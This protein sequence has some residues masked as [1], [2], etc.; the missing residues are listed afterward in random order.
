MDRNL[1]DRYKNIPNLIESSVNMEKSNSKIIIH[2]GDFILKSNKRELQITGEI[3][4][5]W[6]PNKGTEFTGL[7]KN[8]NEDLFQ[9]FDARENLKLIINDLEMGEVFITK[10][11]SDIKGT[12]SSQAVTGDKSISV[13]KLNFSIPNLREFYGNS[14]KKISDDKIYFTRGRIELEA[15][16][17]I[18]RIDKVDN[19]KEL[20]SD[21]DENGGYI[22]LYGGEIVSKN[23]SISYLDAEKIIYQL[24]TFL[25]FINGRRTSALMING[26]Y[27]NETKWCDYTSYFVDTF[28]SSVTT[29]PTL[30][31][32][33]T[34]DSLWKNYNEIWK[35]ENHRDFLATAIHWYVEANNNS[36]FAEGSII[37]A[38]TAL[39]LIYNWWIIENKKL[40]QGKDSE[41]LSASNKIRLLISHLDILSDVP[42][43]FENLQK[44]VDNDKQ[45]NDAPEAIVQ[46]RNAV[47]HSQQEKR[48]K[49]ISI[50]LL[51]KYE[52]LQLS[53]W[54]I[55]LSILKILNFNGNYYN[56]TSSELSRSKSEELVPWMKT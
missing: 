28:K 35:D 31:S 56:R 10:I 39:E 13:E 55:E 20:K 12:F 17:Y 19:F 3:Y 2:K 46:I 47:V 48:K 4:F 34:F 30:N 6:I 27:E 22:I 36:G 50:H 21:L 8:S 33:N 40:I 24:N 49:L 38:Q 15:N 11:G 44:F 25:T 42:M 14:I 52:A 41:S 9:F 26:I 5:R 7:T 23:G 54:Y 37:M 45:I 53:L 16:E 51:A 18:I 43:G 32:I 1:T 29:W